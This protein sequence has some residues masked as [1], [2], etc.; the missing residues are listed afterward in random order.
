MVMVVYNSLNP[1]IVD[2]Q[3]AIETQPTTE[4]IPAVVTEEKS[5]LE[6]KM[7]NFNNFMQINNT[8]V[9][10]QINPWGATL[11]EL[12]CTPS[13]AINTLNLLG[14]NLTPEQMQEVIDNLTWNEKSHTT[15]ADAVLVSLQQTGDS[16]L[17][18]A[19]KYGTENRILDATELT[20]YT[21]IL[22]YGGW[23]TG[24]KGGD[25][26]LNEEIV[27]HVATITCDK[28]DCYSID[29]YFSDGKPVKC[30]AATA[31]KIECGNF[32][33][34]VGESPNQFPSLLYPVIN[35]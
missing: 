26:S 6:K 23:A 31:D 3:N 16:T 25:T 22:I 9:K 30:E 17:K 4:K 1:P 13:S 2:N 27:N 11:L 24:Y 8:S 18:G 10:Q 5:E 15:G 29:S 35:H 28:G 14:F 12:G 34:K 21:G 19:A 20:D 7:E 32:E 33:Y